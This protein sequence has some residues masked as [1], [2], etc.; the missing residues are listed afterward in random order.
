MTSAVGL[1]GLDRRENVVG[2]CER[3]EASAGRHPLVESRV[4]RYH[5]SAGGE[6]DR[7][8]VTEPTAPGHY[9]SLLRDPEFALRAADESPVALG[10]ASRDT[11]VD[12]LPSLAVELGEFR[13][14]AIDVKGERET[15]VCP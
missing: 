5:R 13:L 11:R 10:C 15:H 9:V 3:E 1:D 4:L 8:A 12:D 14:G 7:A 2:H 6:V